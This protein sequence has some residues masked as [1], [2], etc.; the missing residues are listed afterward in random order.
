M[1]V[2]KIIGPVLGLLIGGVIAAPIGALFAKCLDPRLMFTFVG[3][4]IT[5]TSGL[6]ILKIT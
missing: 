4:A 2:G 1:G 5:L 3:L 6:A